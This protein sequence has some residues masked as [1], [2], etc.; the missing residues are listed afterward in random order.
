MPSLPPRDGVDARICAGIRAGALTVSAVNR[1][2][3]VVG[4]SLPLPPTGEHDAIGGPSGIFLLPPCALH[5]H[6]G[7]SPHTRPHDRSYGWMAPSPATTEA[8]PP[9]PSLAHPS[10]P[11]WSY[12]SHPHQTMGGIP[13]GLM[14]PLPA[15]TEVA[16]PSPSS[17]HPFLPTRSSPTHPLPTMG[18]SAALAAGRALPRSLQ[19]LAFAMSTDPGFADKNWRPSTL[20]PVSSNVGINDTPF[21]DTW[22]GKLGDALPPQHSSAGNG[23]SGSI[24]GSP[25]RTYSARN[26]SACSRC[27][28]AHWRTPCRSG[29]IAN[30]LPPRLTNPPTQ[31][32]SVIP[33]RIVVC[34]YHNGGGLDEIIVLVVAR[35]E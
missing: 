30:H 28:A 16:T 24:A 15:T 14:A 8:T 19:C 13:K 33:P 26:A 27:V 34:R 22:H 6:G 35:V 1:L 23:A 12:P 29:V 32:S 21:V 3:H 5:E 7:G 11:A 17:A 31:R 10:P 4:T 2:T 9:S 25:S 18:G 20:L